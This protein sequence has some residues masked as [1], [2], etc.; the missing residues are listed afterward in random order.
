MPERAVASA[1]QGMRLSKGKMVVEIR[2]PVGSRGRE[3]LSLHVRQAYPAVT[4][5][6]AVDLSGELPYGWAD[7]LPGLFAGDEKPLA[8]REASNRVM[9]A[10]AQVRRVEG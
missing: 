1:A 10:I 8:T 3:G 5:Q 9:N 2:P 4:A 6:L 7:E